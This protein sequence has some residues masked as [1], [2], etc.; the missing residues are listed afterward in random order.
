M[1]NSIIKKLSYEISDFH[2]KIELSDDGRKAYKEFCLCEEGFTATLSAAQNEFYNQLECCF[3]DYFAECSRDYYA[4][5]FRAGLLVG[6]D[7]ANGLED[8]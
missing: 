6:V 2:E 8:D 7:A 4:A 1:K 3:F 5:G